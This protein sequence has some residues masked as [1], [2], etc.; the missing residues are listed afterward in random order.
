MCSFMADSAD[1]SHLSYTRCADRLETSEHFSPHPLK[2]NRL[3]YSLLPY[4]YKRYPLIGF[5]DRL[6]V[7]K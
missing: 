2:S 6:R 4:A 7:R 1:Q 3:S 5:A